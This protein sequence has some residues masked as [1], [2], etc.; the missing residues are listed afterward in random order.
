LKSKLDV[1]NCL[2]VSFGQLGVICW[3]EQGI[4]V[5]WVLLPALEVDKK[6]GQLLPTISEAG[7]TSL[8]DS[9]RTHEH[10]FLQLQADAHSRGV[11]MHQ[12]A[13]RSGAIMEFG[14]N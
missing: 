13:R 6:L 5:G 11:Q 7:L 1:Q 12:T 3:I 10:A 8:H 9:Q 14:E 2:Y 4:P